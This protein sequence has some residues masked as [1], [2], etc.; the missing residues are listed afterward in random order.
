MSNESYLLLITYYLLLITYYLLLITYYLLLITYYFA[1]EVRALGEFN[2]P[3]SIPS[4]LVRNA[5]IAN[6]HILVIVPIFYALVGL[7]CQ[8]HKSLFPNA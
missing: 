4:L 1:H 6:L 3:S 2:L 7:P 8:K 5:G